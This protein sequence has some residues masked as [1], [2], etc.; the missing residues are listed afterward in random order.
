MSSKPPLEWLTRGLRLPRPSGRPASLVVGLVAALALAWSSHAGAVGAAVDPIGGVQSA[1][2]EF[3]GSQSE[4]RSG[5]EFEEARTTQSTRRLRLRDIERVTH[6]A[7][8]PLRVEVVHAPSTRAVARPVVDRC[9]GR[10]LLIRHRRL[11]I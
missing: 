3:E 2:L 8:H 9:A 7:C 11:L 10:D 6:L 4:P 5:E 1:L